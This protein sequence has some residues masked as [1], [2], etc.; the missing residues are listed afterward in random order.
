MY[1]FSH[2]L[3]TYLIAYT[4]YRRS[5]GDILETGNSEATNKSNVK[6]PQM[7]SAD[8]VDVEN[9]KLTSTATIVTHQNASSA[10][11][12][13]INHEK[14]A[15]NQQAPQV[16]P[17]PAPRSLST[18]NSIPLTNGNSKGDDAAQVRYEHFPHSFIS[19]YV[20]ISLLR[21]Y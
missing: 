7:N 3:R 17:R 20:N 2:F 9:H 6:D 18:Q 15:Q 12:T 4:G 13:F 11:D 1:F 8:V 21:F 10:S 14:D 19:R 16:A 5:I